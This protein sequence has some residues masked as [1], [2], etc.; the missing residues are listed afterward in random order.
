MALI[1]ADKLT[2]QSVHEKNSYLKL[3]EGPKLGQWQ[4]RLSHSGKKKKINKWNS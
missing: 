2:R 4:T 1:L 3:L